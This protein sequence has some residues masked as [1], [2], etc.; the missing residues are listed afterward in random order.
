MIMTMSDM[1]QKRIVFDSIIKR[2]FIYMMNLLY[3]KQFSFDCLFNDKSAFKYP[4]SMAW[5]YFNKNSKVRFTVISPA[6]AYS[7]C[8]DGKK[9]W[10][11]FSL[12]IMAF[13]KTSRIDMCRHIISFFLKE[14]SKTPQM[15]TY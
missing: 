2:I 3:R 15:S 13:F 12:H 11:V 10:M 5:T 9:I 1:R 6:F 7:F 14:Y 8:K 4:I